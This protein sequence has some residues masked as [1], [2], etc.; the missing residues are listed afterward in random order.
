MVKLVGTCS[1]KY[2]IQL[3]IEIM[4]GT[5][6]KSGY[7]WEIDISEAIPELPVSEFFELVKLYE[8]I[9]FLSSE[10]NWKLYTNKTQYSI[11]IKDT[12]KNNYL[13]ERLQIRHL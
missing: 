2:L 4:S 12:L 13:K 9:G 11:L 10:E 7:D 6:F 5:K 1:E 3:F 8:F